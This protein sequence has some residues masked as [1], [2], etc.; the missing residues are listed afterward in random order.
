MPKIIKQNKFVVIY[1][2]VWLIPTINITKIRNICVSFTMWRL[3]VQVLIQLDDS[4]KLRLH[5]CSV[6]S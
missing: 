2:I 3:K 6:S 1:E 4:K 5:H